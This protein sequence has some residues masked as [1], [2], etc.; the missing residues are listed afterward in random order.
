M[1]DNFQCRDVLL[2]RTREGQGPTLLAVGLG[3]GCLD[4]FSR[5]SYLSLF[6]LFLG[7]GPM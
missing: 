7:D 6:S 2:I 1:L 5:L 4:I 3:G